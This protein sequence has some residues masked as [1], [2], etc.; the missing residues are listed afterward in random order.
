MTDVSIVLIHS[1][2]RLPSYL[3]E[4]IRQIRKWFYGRVYLGLHQVGSSS[5][6]C[7][8]GRITLRIPVA[9]FASVFNISVVKIDSL[10]GWYN[11]S[12]KL[13]ASLGVFGD[14]YTKAIS[15]LFILQKLI[16][17]RNLHN[18]VHMENDVMLYINPSA[19]AWPRHGVFINPL[20]E[21]FGTWAFTYI[22]APEDL[23]AVNVCHCQLLEHG[24]DALKARYSHHNVNEMLFAG[25]LLRS[26]AVKALPTLPKDSIECLYD[27]SAYGQYAGGTHEA[28][29]GFA[30]RGRY[31]G[32]AL[33]DGKIDLAWRTDDRNRRYPVCLDLINGT[34]TRLANLHIHCKRLH[35]F[36]S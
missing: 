26:K 19:C 23:E 5:V 11:N 30:E 31:V 25:E 8:F 32:E 3:F 34:E 16:S 33:L 4:C 21:K 29:A 36:R 2:G 7:S 13:S 17:D 18:V 15:R 10:D 28:P 35:D 24:V 20:S 9:L 6:Q 1:G 12:L 27:G 22:A 14:L